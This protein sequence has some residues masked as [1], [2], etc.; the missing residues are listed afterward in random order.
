MEGVLRA[1]FAK[2][3]DTPFELASVLRT[4]LSAAPHPFRPSQ[5]DQAG[6][7]SELSA[8]SGREM[9]RTAR[10]GAKAAGTGVA[11]EN[12]YSC[13]APAWGTDRPP[14]A[15]SRL[16]PLSQEGIDAPLLAGFP[17]GPAPAPHL[18]A[19]AQGE[20]GANP[21]AAPVHHPG[22]RRSRFTGRRHAPGRLMASGGSRRPISR[23]SS[24]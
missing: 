3:G 17:G 21:V 9:V 23:I 19:Q 5:G 7:L 10:A 4:R 11:G 2:T 8:D 14:G 22:A 24:S 15:A 12:R 20:R 6:V 18:F 1:Q 13:P 16:S